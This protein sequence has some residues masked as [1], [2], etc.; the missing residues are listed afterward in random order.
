MITKKCLQLVFGVGL[1]VAPVLAQDLS[2]VTD[3]KTMAFQARA[4]RHPDDYRAFKPL[5]QEAQNGNRDAL[6]ALIE[7]VRDPQ[8]A[9]QASNALGDIGPSALPALQTL[10]SLLYEID[11]PVPRSRIVSAIGKIGPAAEPAVGDLVEILR[12]EPKICSSATDALAR[13]GR[14]P[15][16]TVP[17]LAWAL[18]NGSLDCRMRA[19]EALGSFQTTP[20]VEAL[21]TVLSED[22]IGIAALESLGRI[23]PLAAMAED[24]IVDLL[25][26]EN[27]SVREAAE[28][29]MTLITGRPGGADIGGDLRRAILSISDRWYSAHR[30]DLN[31]DGVCV[32][33][34]PVEG[35]FEVSVRVDFNGAHA[36]GIRFPIDGEARRVVAAELEPLAEELRQNAFPV[37]INPKPC[38]DLISTASA[39]RP[40][41]R[42]GESE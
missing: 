21:A 40:P 30:D 32:S 26:S 22:F 41:V 13:I 23:G 39:S 11:D 2:P 27:N 10:R 38:F 16:I 25:L 8:T 6:T 1:C 28:L 14:S 9:W 33:P 3:H 29:T 5:V 19:I 31:F 20:A 17:A 37:R 24:E 42:E 35:R 4:R 12:T 34:E 36:E 7:L 18:D 15:G